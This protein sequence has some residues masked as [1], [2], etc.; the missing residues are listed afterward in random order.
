[1]QKREIVWIAALLLVI[2]VYICCFSH[3][4]EKR[5]I[6]VVASVRPIRQARRRN[7][8]APTNSPAFQVVFTL[9]SY[10]SL[11][12]VELTEVD[13]THPDAVKPALWKLVPKSNSP[14][15]KL[16]TYGQVIKGLEPEFAGDQPE[17][18]V[19]GGIYRIQV[20]AGPLKGASPPFTIPDSP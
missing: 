17:P 15:V 4:G 12:G 7:S 9:D 20:S 6:Q 8:P 5:Q 18:L 11:T 10:Y 1:M 19:P 14:P 13:R 2:G 3:W 16:F